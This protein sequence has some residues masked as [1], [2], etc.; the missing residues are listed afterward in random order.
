MAA[1]PY[2]S[3][4]EGPTCIESS[5]VSDGPPD[6]FIVS[7]LYF[8]Q[9]GTPNLSAGPAA[10]SPRLC[11][12]FGLH[13]CAHV[14]PQ[15][16]LGT[17]ILP[18]PSGWTPPQIW[19]QTNHPSPPPIPTSEGPGE[20]S[21]TRGP[22]RGS[23]SLIPAQEPTA[24]V[25]GDRIHRPAA[26]APSASDTTVHR[27]LSFEIP[28]WVTCESCT[29]SPFDREV[30]EVIGAGGGETLEVS[31]T[32]LHPPW[33]QTVLTVARS[34]WASS[35]PG[36]GLQK[37]TCLDA[38]P[39]GSGE[40]W[41]SGLLGVGQEL[42]LDEVIRCPGALDREAGVGEVTMLKTSPSPV[43][44]R[45]KLWAWWGLTGGALLSA[46][47]FLWPPMPA[48]RGPL[49][50]PPPLT[51]LIWHWPFTDQPPDLPGET[52]SHFGAAHCCLSTNRSL[53]ASADAVV[54][55]HRELQNSRVH[56]PLDRR[57]RGQPWVWASMESPSHTHGLSRLG[58]IFN[59]VLS[60][61]RD[62]DIFV[63]YGRLEP[64]E[65][66]LL[67]PS[68]VKSR[69]AAWVV[70]NFQERQ[71]RAKLYRQLA[72]H[73]HIDVFGRA[74]RR[75]LC[76]D[77]L[78]PTVAR[79]HFYLAFENSVHRDYITE[80]FW[81]NALLAGTVPVVLGPPRANYEAFAPPDAFVHVED[82][83]SVHELASFLSSMN[84]TCYQRFFAW[85][86]HLR[87]RLL[88]DWRERFCAICARFPHLPRG[89][90]YEDLEG[91]F[92]GDVLEPQKV[93]VGAMLA[94]S[95]LPSAGLMGLDPEPFLPEL[96]L[97]PQ[98]LGHF[99]GMDSTPETRFAPGQGLGRA[100]VDAADSGS[101][102]FKRGRLGWGRAGDGTK[103]PSLPSPPGRS[104]RRAGPGRLSRPAPARATMPRG[105]AASGARWGAQGNGT[106]L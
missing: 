83:D 3:S 104:R 32:S 80:K 67:P 9:A 30:I 99:F 44:A 41:G 86:D 42:H 81:R 13:C 10:P 4:S 91:W 66:P 6:S 14:Q 103:S 69:L 31:Q 64:L 98:A 95:L 57:P 8:P 61:R 26:S 21:A 1:A 96:G 78:L 65:G 18:Q 34:Q 15:F 60:Y 68:P 55:H 33:C 105:A 22:L 101:G 43:L 45:Q 102:A 90:V 71:Q 75:P 29:S 28:P 73:L 12:S 59:W 76:A 87:V 46:L 79:Y 19:Y 52:C 89:Q 49:E 2:L 70:S 38:D 11:C 23:H 63:P 56:L 82:F 47:W 7:Q 16:H 77:C 93:K 50:P 94:G 54:F 27:V 48:P 62:S 17:P 72:P 5:K 53:L 92:Q 36:Q 84:E 85:H 58:G 35:V 25:V 106:R 97:S 100:L 37:V 24:A 39:L 51:I 88:N 20:D 74:N 40:Q